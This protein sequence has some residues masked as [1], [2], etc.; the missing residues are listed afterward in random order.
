MAR[1][2]FLQVQ[3]FAYP[4]LYYLCGALR[5]AGH[6]YEVIAS[7]RPERVFDTITRFQ[8]DLIGFPTMTGLHKEILQMAWEIKKK[9]PRNNIILGGIHPTLFPNSIRDEHIDFICRGEGERPLVLLLEAIAS[10]QTSFAIPNISYKR[11]DEIIHND[12][13]QLVDPMDSLPFPDYTIYRNAPVIASDTFPMVF[14]T[15]GC[16]F[17]CTYCHNS[18]QK[19]IYRGLGKYVRSFTVD[20][21]LDE[22][23]AACEAYPGARAIMLGADTIGNDM[24]WLRELLMRYRERFDI[25]Y[26]CLVRPELIT[27]ELVLLFKNTNCHM[28]A[29]GIES[30]SERVRRELLHRRYSN[31]QIIDAAVCLKKHGIGFRTYNI[32]GFP[33]ETREEMLETLDLNLRINPDFP[34]CSIYTPYPETALA[35]FS[36]A[37]GYLEKNFSYDNVPTSFFN[38]TILRN[39]DRKFILNLH[40]FFQ[41][42]VLMPFFAS[43]LRW[44]MRFPPNGLYRTIFKVVY[45]YTSLRSERRTLFSFLKLAFANRRLFK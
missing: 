38:D 21:V 37:H 34:W 8:P 11:G 41:L 26:A 5:S 16:P 27:E 20:R 7:N 25:P 43:F 13:Q 42:A 4:G 15:R 44:L 9:F 32:V 40:S 17:S 6:Q 36:V 23:K 30:G 28:V 29:F 19:K 18:N 14:M 10:G 31:K 3:Q 12:M 45:A 39:V 22:V 35:E 33:T 24:L 1:M 2:L